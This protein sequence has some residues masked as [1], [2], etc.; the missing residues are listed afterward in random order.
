VPFYFSELGL[1][2]KKWVGRRWRAFHPLKRRKI[3]GTI[4]VV[5]EVL[6][7][8]LSLLLGKSR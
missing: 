2:V 6:E 3:I 7:I 5:I 1:L 4:L 8:V